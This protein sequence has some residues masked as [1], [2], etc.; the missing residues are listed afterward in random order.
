MISAW[1]NE[2]TRI[3]QWALGYSKCSVRRPSFFV[4]CFWRSC[5]KRYRCVSFK[6]CIRTPQ[7]CAVRSPSSPGNPCPLSCVLGRDHW[8]CWS[9]RI[10]RDWCAAA[11]K[12]E[13]VQITLVEGKYR[14]I[15]T[16]ETQMLLC[17]VFVHVLWW[18][19]T[20]N[21]SNIPK[22]LCQ[23]SLKSFLF[24]FFIFTFLWCVFG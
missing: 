7:H 10:D 24:L 19:Q 23:L 5:G 12:G 11:A 1:I 3:I 13:N 17:L 20:V 14:L 22:E 6:R 2:S 8:L 9:G 15:F 16:H 21:T 4:G 18:V